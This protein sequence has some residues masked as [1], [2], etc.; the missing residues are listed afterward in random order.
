MAVRGTI[1]HSACTLLVDP[2]GDRTDQSWQPNKNLA[3]IGKNWLLVCESFFIL[4]FQPPQLFIRSTAIS[5]ILWLS[6]PGGVT[7]PPSNPTFRTVNILE[8]YEYE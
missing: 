8:I 7:F 1:L 4:G 2:L 3:A 5:E 6:S